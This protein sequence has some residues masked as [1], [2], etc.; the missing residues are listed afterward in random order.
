MRK[1]LIGPVLTGVGWLAG[2]HY[3]AQAKQLVHKDPDTTYAGVARALDG[4]PDHGT[5]HFEGGTPVPYELR[6]EHDAGR[7]LVVHVLFGG[8]EGGSTEIDFAAQG[9]DTLMTATA[10]ADRAVLSGA[11]AGTD[12]ARLAYAPDWMLNLVAV[13][14][15]LKQLGEQIEQG[16]PPEFGGMSRAEWESSL[17]PD[18]Q[19][20]VQDSRQY[21]AAAPTTDPDA[22]A[23]NYMSGK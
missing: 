10:H 21:E 9:A 6:I 3:G 18:Q 15:L 20:Q 14:P 8:R 5:T 13:R 1:F 23:R 19:K 11:L 16:R 17:P 2:S 7:Q 12:K 4:I 22:D